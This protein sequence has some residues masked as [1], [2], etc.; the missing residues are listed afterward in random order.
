MSL[1]ISNVT[2]KGVTKGS[3]RLVTGTRN[4]IPTIYDM[5]VNLSGRSIPGIAHGHILPSDSQKRAQQVKWQ[6]DVI[7][8]ILVAQGA[9]FNSLN[10]EQLLDWS[11]YVNYCKAEM[12]SLDVKISII[13]HRSRSLDHRRPQLLVIFVDGGP[14]L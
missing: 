4:E 8:K 2:K 5:I 9:K 13:C 14:I 11:D 6:N 10:G 3:T 1:D 7:I 12:I